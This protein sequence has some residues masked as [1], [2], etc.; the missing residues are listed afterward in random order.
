MGILGKRYHYVI[1]QDG[2][3]PVWDGEHT[4]TFRNPVSTGDHI[5]PVRM[6][7][8]VRKVLRIEHYRQGSVL[9][10]QEVSGTDHRAGD[11][12]NLLLH[13]LSVCRL[14]RRTLHLTGR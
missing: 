8:K 4:E 6:G 7:E 14:H 13:D 10:V 9:Y 2:Y 5:M 12:R 1:A 3:P 11:G